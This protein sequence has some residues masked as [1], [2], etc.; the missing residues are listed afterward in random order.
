MDKNIYI[1]VCIGQ[2]MIMGTSHK[3]TKKGFIN[4]YES[5]ADKKI[6]LPEDR[7]QMPD[8]IVYLAKG[9]KEQ[10]RISY[11]RIRAQTLVTST[12][13]PMKIYELKADL[14]LMN[15]AKDES[16]GYL[17]FRAQLFES[18]PPPPTNFLK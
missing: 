15:I 16:A 11:F 8:L 4:F 18:I 13:M 6:S 10:D 14:S 3:Y 17:T 2:Y 7:S 9:L 12:F 1:H 5:L